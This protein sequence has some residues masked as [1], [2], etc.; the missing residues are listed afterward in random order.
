[1][2]ILRVYI[3]ANQRQTSSNFRY[4][5]SLQTISKDLG[6]SRPTDEKTQKLSQTKQNKM[7][8]YLVTLITYIL[9]ICAG[10]SAVTSS[11]NQSTYNQCHSGGVQAACLALK[12]IK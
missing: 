5:S 2:A 9:L 4:S 7:K 11:L 8:T 6:L 12:G 1:M 10:V 3:S